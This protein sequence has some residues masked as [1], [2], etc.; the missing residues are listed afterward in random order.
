MKDIILHKELD[1]TGKGTVY[2]FSLS[3]N[4]L[5]MNDLAI[6]G[7]ITI[8]GVVRK[9]SAIELARNGFGVFQDTVGVIAV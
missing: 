6:G 8:N 9:I 5:H 4:K 3:D 7:N 1:V 2:V